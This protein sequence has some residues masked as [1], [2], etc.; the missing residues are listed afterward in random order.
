MLDISSDFSLFYILLCILLGLV[1]AILLYNKRKGLITNKLNLFLFISRAFFT[2]ILAFLL[3]SPVFRTNVRSTSKPIVI[4]AKDHSSSIK[5]NIDDSF[6]FL[7]EGLDDFDVFMCSFAEKLSDGLSLKNDGL[8][9]NYSKLFTEISNRFENTNVAGLILASDGS[10]NAGSNPE[11]L[12]YDFPI[13]CLALGDTTKY[14]DIRIDNVIKNDIVFLDNTFPLEISLACN[15]TKKEE[16]KLIIWNNGIKEYEKL[17]I[18]SNDED[19]KT[20]E[21]KLP[22]NNVGLQNYTIE[23]KAL[24][25]EKNISNNFF[26]IYIDVIDSR[27]NILILKKN[28]SPDIAA[29]KNSIEKNINYKIDVKDINDD[30]TIDEYQLVVIFG[31]E[32]IPQNLI[33]NDIP[34]I[35]F[36]SNQSFYSSLDFPISFIKDGELEEVTTYKSNSFSKFSFSPR[37][38]KLI[39]ESPPLFTQFGR[40]N[41]NGNVD[42]ILKQKI[43]SFESNKPIIMLQELN[44]RKIAYITAEGWWKWKLYDYNY[45]DNNLAFDE[46]FSKLT[47]YLILQEDRSLF[48]LQYDRHYEEN[49]EIIFRASLYNEIYELVNDKEIDLKLTNDHDEE[50]YFQFFRENNELIANLGSLPIGVY[51]FSATVKGSNIIKEG[52][53]HIKKIHVESIGLS[54]NHQILH[55]IA[56]LSNGKVFGLDNFFDLIETIKNSERNKV[57]INSRE[58]LDSLINISWILFCLLLLISIEWFVRKYNGLV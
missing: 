19:Y 11:F 58:K 56:A 54:A 33:N 57:V 14:K 7:K 44:S 22:A 40:Y 28:N 9:T 36:N 4:L 23:L 53:F 31:V 24:D 26:E 52:V 20:V 30:F 47:Q 5:E 41:Y 50:F 51:N 3:L 37:L 55:K 12:S 39:S 45:N 29:Y 27:N 16:S 48:R 38:L 35:I 49:D 2:S 18:F 43:G 42:F 34:L 21:I 13:Y 10:Y 25:G 6:N 17:F 15:V 46:L 32:N 8:R 1:Y